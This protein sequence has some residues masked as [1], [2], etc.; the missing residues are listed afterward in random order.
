MWCDQFDCVKNV[1]FFLLDC[2]NRWFFQRK[3]WG[4][5]YFYHKGLILIIKLDTKTYFFANIQGLAMQIGVPREIFAN[6]TRVAATPKTVEQLLK[7]GFVNAPQ[8]NPETGV[9]EIELIKDGASLVSFIWPAQNPELLEKLSAKNINVMAMDSVPRISRA[10][11][12][13][14]LSSIG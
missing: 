9:D 5:L 2:E 13:D 8:V 10:Q 12:L 3:C 6:E 4:F 14:A 1:L 11:A 7:M